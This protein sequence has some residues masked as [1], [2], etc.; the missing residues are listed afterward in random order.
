M[1]S[2]LRKPAVDEEPLTTTDVESEITKILA[3]EEPPKPVTIK[4]KIVDYGR[5]MINPKVLLLVLL[6]FGSG[7]ASNYDWTSL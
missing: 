1:L 2:L 6:M 7:M 3:Q 5:M 4:D